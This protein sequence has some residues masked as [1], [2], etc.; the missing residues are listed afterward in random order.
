MSDLP[1]TSSKISPRLVRT[2][3]VVT[4][5]TIGLF[6]SLVWQVWDAFGY[7]KTSQKNY[8]RLSEL[9]G[10]IVHLDEVLT[11]SARMA[12]ATGER[13]WE[14][15]YRQ[16]EEKLDAAIKETM[17][18]SQG[19]SLS[20]A[21]DKTNTANLKLVEMENRAFD[22]VRNGQTEKAADTLSS[23]EY[24][25]QKKLYITGITQ[26]METIR[27]SMGKDCTQ[28]RYRLYWAIGSILIV[29]PCLIFG[30]FL[31]IRLSRQYN[32]NRKQAEDVLRESE[33]RFR[34]L[35]QNLHIVALVIDPVDGS[36]VDANPAASSFYGWSRDELLLKKI[37]EINTLPRQDTFKE[38]DAALKERRSYFLFQ[39]CR[40]DDSVRDVEVY[41]GPVRVGAKELLYSIVHDITDRKL[42]E[43]KLR[44]TT[45]LLRTFMDA[46]NESAFLIDKQWRILVANETVAKRFNKTVQQ[47]IGSEIEDIFSLDIVSKRKPHLDE[48]FTTGKS[49][50]F[51]DERLGRNIDNVVYPVIDPQGEVFALAI[52]GH[53][54]TERKRT[55]ETLVEERRRLQQALDEVRTLR[56]I[57]PICANCKKIRDDNGYWSQVEKYISEHTE[58]R[59]SHGICP[60]CSKALYP[61]LFEK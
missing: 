10:Q 6:G 23:A 58:V 15:R 38:M 9:S 1:E 11:M 3:T 43:E 37:T 34:S 33:E 39:H 48:A 52:V 13:M 41:S 17:D 30:W 45:A 31:V 57:V 29:T 8:F 26:I 5:L 24:N 25:L 12:S 18:L 53:D 20:N 42:T 60:D 40:A 27:G 14:I 46:I 4:V 22:L 61:E 59:F 56:G 35:F 16:Y 21:A 55:E 2:F 32:T 51:E 28:Y 47:L 44:L 54:I 36:I 49:V 50:R 7:L 19:F